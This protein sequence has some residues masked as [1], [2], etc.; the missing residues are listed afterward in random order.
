VTK[1][2]DDKGVDLIVDQISGY[3]ANQNLAA[4]K[5]LGRI[6]NVGRLGGFTGE[7]NFDLHAARRI[8]YIGVTFRTRSIEEIHEIVQAMQSDLWPAVQA[9]KLHL[10][11]DREFSLDQAAEAVEY[12]KANRHFGKIILLVN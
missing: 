2:T 11:I 4:T 8:D 12:M 3:A 6:I 1:A 10:P 7:F 5:V 9:G